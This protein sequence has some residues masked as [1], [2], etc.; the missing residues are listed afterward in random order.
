MGY[1]F[2]QLLPWQAPLLDYLQIWKYQIFQQWMVFYDVRLDANDQGILNQFVIKM[3]KSIPM[4]VM[5]IV[6]KQLSTVMDNHVHVQNLNQNLN[7]N[8]NLN[9]NPIVEDV[10]EFFLPF[11]EVMEK[12]IIILAWQIAKN[13]VL[14]AK[15]NAHVVVLE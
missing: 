5:L 3:A 6:K 7:L 1:S 13:W 8:L 2:Y 4:N 9:L 12:L 10:Q 11:V 15:E 14:H